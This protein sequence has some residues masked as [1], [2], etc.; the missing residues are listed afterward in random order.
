MTVTNPANN[1]LVRHRE[2]MRAAGLRPVQFW[3]PDTRAPEFVAQLR[4]Q[5]L[6]LAN[7][8]VEAEV[9]GFTE[10]AATHIDSWQ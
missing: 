1:K 8:P 10:Q 5:C 7:D 6:Q 3:V 4:L 9:L 2:R